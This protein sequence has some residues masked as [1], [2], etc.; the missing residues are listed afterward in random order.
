[1]FR[2]I[3]KEYELGVEWKDGQTV[4]LLK[5]GKYG[6]KRRIGRKAEVF[7]T[8]KT[9]LRIAGQEVILGDRT[10]LKINVA[11][12][13]RISDPVALV[14]EVSG[15][16]LSDHLNQVVQITLKDVLASKTLDDLLERREAVNDDFMKK[17]SAELK[18]M[19][20]EVTDIK[21]KDI[22]LPAEL[23][24]AYTES[25]SAQL[26]AKAQ[27]EQA[28]GQSAALRNLANTADLLDR[29]PQLVQL[30]TLQ[31]KDSILNLYFEQSAPTAKAHA[32]NKAKSD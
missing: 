13:Y 30:L 18:Q 16:E 9:A 15:D 19:G 7:D 14:K 2:K 8:R 11:G 32:K 25:L 3:I 17:V 1:M 24:S 10:S 29:H 22:I 26:K 28:R 21:I 31:K 6:F 20:L 4:G 12:M 23:R 27:L 5:P